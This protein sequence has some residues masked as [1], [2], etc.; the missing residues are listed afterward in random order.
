MGGVNVLPAV[1]SQR[2]QSGVPEGEPR[3]ERLAVGRQVDLPRRV[4]HRAQQAD[5]LRAGDLAGA[6]EFRDGRRDVDQSHLAADPPAGRNAAARRARDQ[7]DRDR[8]VVDEER[9]PLLAVLAEALAVIAEQHD[10]GVLAKAERVQ[11]GQQPADLR[12][13]VGDLVE[14]RTRVTAGER[15]RGRVRFVRVEEVGEQEER[16]VRGGG[17]PQ[18][19]DRMVGDLVR[20][21]LDPVLAEVVVDLEALVEAE[22]AIQHVGAQFRRGEV[23]A[24]AE[25]L[26]Q[27]HVVV[28]QLKRAVVPD[29][30]DERIDAGHQAGVGGQRDRRRRHAVLEQRALGGEAIDVGRGPLRVTVT[31][32]MIGAGRVQRDQQDV[33]VRPRGPVPAG[34]A[35][36]SACPQASDSVSR[37]RPAPAA[38]GP[39]PQVEIRWIVIF[40]S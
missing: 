40:I 13:D 25:D 2:A 22:F 30:V 11:L 27:R 16:P 12:I 3:K 23:A 31:A 36:A 5:T 20:P 33:E 9:V 39:R 26:G 1:R 15:S 7:R 29:A 32:E 17:G 19:V 6:D 18:R 14:V 28:A 10:Q 24:L 8:R 4:V 34:G 35:G 38:S 21:A 37:S